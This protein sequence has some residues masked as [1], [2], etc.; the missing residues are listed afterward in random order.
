MA[1]AA[2]VFG[3]EPPFKGAELAGECIGF[4]CALFCQQAATGPQI[5]GQKN[6]PGICALAAQVTNTA[7][8]VQ[9]LEALQPKPII[10]LKKPGN[11]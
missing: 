5:I 8:M 7:V 6:P 10:N 2:K 4:E 11:N 9:M 1:E 3:L